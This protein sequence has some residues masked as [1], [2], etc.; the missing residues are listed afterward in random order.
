MKSS[1]FVGKTEKNVKISFFL[2]HK[3]KQRKAE[4]FQQRVKEKRE[5]S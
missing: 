1:L 2:K 5:E 4:D 3:E